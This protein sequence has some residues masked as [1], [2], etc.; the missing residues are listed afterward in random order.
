MAHALAPDA[1]KGDF[2]AAAIADNAAVLD[3]LVFAAG[4]LPVLDRTE[5]AFAEETALFGFES[6]VVDRFRVLHLALGPGADGFRGSDG[7]PD[8]VDEIDLV[9]AQQVAGVFFGANHES[10][11]V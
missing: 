6:A 3:A 1:G 2:D 7:D 5:D 4:A 8:V 11:S 10:F 9:E